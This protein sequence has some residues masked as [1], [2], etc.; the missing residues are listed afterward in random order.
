MYNTYAEDELLHYGVKGMKWG[1]RRAGKQLSKA[2]DSKSRQDAV[3][4]LN[5]HKTKSAA[6]LSKLEKK[7]VKLD[8]K[9]RKATTKD[10][11]KASKLEAKATK[12]DRKA[13]KEMDK[14]YKWYTSDKK[15]AELIS[16]ANVRK[17]K[18]NKLHAKASSLN[19]KYEKAKSKVEANDTMIKAFKKGINDI[20]TMLVDSGKRYING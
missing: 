1:I 13:T 17:I 9:L 14:A 11:V 18:A 2:T 19:A 10:K 6:K 8:D 7:S 16:K 4:S 3:N 15:S 12:L 5:K 20:D